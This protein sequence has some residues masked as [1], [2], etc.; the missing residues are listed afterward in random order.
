[1]H[2]PRAS[3]APPA[4]SPKSQFTIEARGN[5]LLVE[6]SGCLQSKLEATALQD[7]VLA[8]CRAHRVRRVI[9]DN[10]QSL[11]PPEEVRDLM[12]RWVGDPAHLERVALVL[13][14]TMASVRANMT[15]VS[16]G[17]RLRSFTTVD[18]ARAWIKE[19]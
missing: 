11:V 2:R 18:D 9:F 19:G 1:M 8:A 14:S 5:H 4:P 16:H 7:A 6:Q 10:R 3:Q 15:A 12:W 13:E 17:V